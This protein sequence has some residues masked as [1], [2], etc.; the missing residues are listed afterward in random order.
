MNPIS[1]MHTDFHRLKIN[2]NFFEI[3]EFD[4]LDT[5]G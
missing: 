5:L 1:S 4:E 3:S 2:Q